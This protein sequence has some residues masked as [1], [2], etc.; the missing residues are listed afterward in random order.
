M[1]EDWETSH[2]DGECPSQVG[3]VYHR[4]VCF[5]VCSVSIDRLSG[6]KILVL[7]QDRMACF[8]GQDD[9]SIGQDGKCD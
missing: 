2:L 3:N 9:N 1:V 5:P 8:S 4:P 7:I 6:G